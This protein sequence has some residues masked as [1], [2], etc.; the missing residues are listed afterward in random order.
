MAIEAP[1]LPPCLGG[2]PRPKGWPWEPTAGPLLPP[3][4]GL[5]GSPSSELAALR[6]ELRAERAEFRGELAAL[7]GELAALRGE[8]QAERATWR[9]GAGDSTTRPAQLGSG[10]APKDL[11]AFTETF[12][13][14]H[15]GRRADPQGQT[16]PWTDDDVINRQYSLDERRAEHAVTQEL[17]Q[18]AQGMDTKDKLALSIAVRYRQSAR[19]AA[20][21]FA[22]AIQRGSLEQDVLVPL[23]REC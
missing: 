18:A 3:A 6:E 8:L 5:E 23:T 11:V 17:L 21:R 20:A 2:L 9:R 22:A 16:W 15:E 14:A 12:R 1:P 10:V 4:A 13:R 19:G 7:R